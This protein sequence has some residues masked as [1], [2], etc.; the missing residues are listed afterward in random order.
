MTGLREE[1]EQ[2]TLVQGC[3]GY[4]ISGVSGDSGT[5]K[6]LQEMTVCYRGPWSPILP[7]GTGPRNES[8]QPSIGAWKIP[9]LRS[10]REEKQGI[11]WLRSWGYWKSNQLKTLQIILYHLSCYYCLLI[12]HPLIIH[13]Q[14]SRYKVCN[15]PQSFRKYW[16][17]KTELHGLPLHSPPF[18]SFTH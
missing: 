12:S 2:R 1:M 3:S 17:S 10:W 8:G 16:K 4:P 13:A 14:F 18:D 7:G 6:A 5:N 9:A 15:Y 11:T